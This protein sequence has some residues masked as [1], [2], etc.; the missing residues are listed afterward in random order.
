MDEEDGKKDDDNVL[1][2]KPRVPPEAEAL[3]CPECDC[4]FW[5]VDEERVVR[6]GWCYWE[7]DGEEEDE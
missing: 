4:P 6:C 2:F 5:S 7:L 3:C 1:K